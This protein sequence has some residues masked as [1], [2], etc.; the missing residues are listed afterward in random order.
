MKILVS[1]ILLFF[2]SFTLYAQGLISGKVT[3]TE[4]KKP[5]SNATVFLNG[6]S[7]S[8]KTDEQ[9]LFK[10]SK[11]A[12]GQYN[13]VVSCIGYQTLSK[14]V[15]VAKE[16]IELL[17]EISPKAIA[18]EAVIVRPDKNRGRNLE[19]FKREF[20]GTSKFAPQ[21]KIINPDIID[22]AYSEISNKLEASSSEF[23]IVENRALGYRLKILLNDFQRDYKAGYTYYEG[24]TLF[25]ELKGTDAQHKRWMKNRKE[26]YYGSSMHF[27]RS[28]W[29]NRLTAEGFITR[30]LIRKS[31]DPQ[32]GKAAQYLV[33]DPLPL[34]DF[35][36]KTDNPSLLALA[37]DHLLYIVYI[38][39]TEKEVSL[40]VYRP[41]EMSNYPVSIISLQNK[42]AFFDP[43]GIITDP[44]SIVVEGSWADR[45]KI[46]ELLPID[47]QP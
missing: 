22:V 19:M 43:N 8:T 31:K 3:D 40:S 7:L 42:Y 38:N 39:K 44:K 46:P 34:S 6:A 45:G 15:T 14:T 35:V 17:L 18:L 11:I 32:T 2:V 25:E 10:L 21:C 12:A 16:K 28:I 9:G 29:Q 20:L 27:F 30:T 26:A 47:Y 4:T 37:F 23:L 36:R 41:I 5:L 33:K 24:P 13:L 1:Y